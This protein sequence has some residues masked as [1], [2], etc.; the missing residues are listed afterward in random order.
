MPRSSLSRVQGYPQDGRRQL[1]KKDRWRD[2]ERDMGWPS[3]FE[4]CP[5]LYS[6]RAFIPWV[7]HTA[8]WKMQS[9]L[10]IPSVITSIDI[11]FLP[12]KVLF[13]VHHLLFWRP[14]DITWPPFDKGW[15][16]WTPE[17][18]SFLKV[19]LLK[20]L[21][22][23]CEWGARGS[24]LGFVPPPDGLFQ[25]PRGLHRA[26]FCTRKVRILGWQCWGRCGFLGEAW[27]GTF[28]VTDVVGK[29]RTDL[30]GIPLST[31]FA[32]C[33]LTVGS[34]LCVR[35]VCAVPVSLHAIHSPSSKS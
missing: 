28:W 6:S 14:I 31:P 20:F 5:L 16:A 35:K 23:V 7:I 32:R 2:K 29:T 10:N 34:V 17:Q 11:R 27:V 8:R 13:S 26:L 19:F 21:A 9:Q 33:R 25:A 12:A 22:W 24:G 1:M 15:S 18:W 4:W 30:E 3:F